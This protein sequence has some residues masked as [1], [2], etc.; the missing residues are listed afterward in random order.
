MDLINCAKCGRVFGYSGSEVCSRCTG[1][2]EDDFKK[3]KDY[4]Y[5]N[6]GSNIVEVSEATE[7]SEKKI[8]RYLR[9]SRIEVREDDNALLDCEGCGESIKSGRYC[10]KCAGKLKKEFTSVTKPQKEEQ[11][12]L[13]SGKQDT[14]MYI[15][16]IRKNSNRK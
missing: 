5:D 10:D 2:D 16:E 15:A 6:P 8:L 9:E 3:V 1:N 13:N 4:L 11:K 14:K 7:V 12:P